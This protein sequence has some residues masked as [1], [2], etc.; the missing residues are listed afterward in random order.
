M[1]QRSGTITQ[2]LGPVGIVGEVH[3]PN[4]V[5]AVPFRD[6][7]KIVEDLAAYS[8]EPWPKMA[9]CLIRGYLPTPGVAFDER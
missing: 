1:C 4:V 9:V 6:G 5:P 8:L 3:L 2:R 7:N